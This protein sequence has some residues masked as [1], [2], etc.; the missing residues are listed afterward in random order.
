M[1]ASPLRKMG[2]PCDAPHLTMSDSSGQPID[3]ALHPLLF[4]CHLSCVGRQSAIL[5]HQACSMIYGSLSMNTLTHCSPAA[6]THLP[7]H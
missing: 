3:D 1:T 7:G 4:G 2:L 5:Y 6:S